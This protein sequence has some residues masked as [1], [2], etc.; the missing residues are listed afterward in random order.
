[1]VRDMS[2]YIKFKDK[3]IGDMTNISEIKSKLRQ[4]RA[5]GMIELNW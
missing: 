5:K 4:S 3:S 2:R 1:M